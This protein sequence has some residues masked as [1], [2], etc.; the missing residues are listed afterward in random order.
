MVVLH[1]G[2][3]GVLV[4]AAERR[5]KLLVVDS[6]IERGDRRAV[7]RRCTRGYKIWR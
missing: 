3:K 7:H 4:P 1:E 2:D 5:K 6:R